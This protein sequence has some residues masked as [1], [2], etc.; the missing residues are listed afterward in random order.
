MDFSYHNLTDDDKL[1]NR[2]LERQLRIGRN[3][4]VFSASYNNLTKIPFRTLSAVNGTLQFLTLKG[5]S[6]K[7]CTQPNQSYGEL[8][9]N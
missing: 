1:Y 6:F 7:P 2:T 5:N 8:K 9:K 4:I 3:V